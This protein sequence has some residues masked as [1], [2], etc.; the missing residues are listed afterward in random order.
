VAA[1]ESEIGGSNKRRVQVR[2][3][4]G[5]KKAK[6]RRNGFTRERKND[7]LAHF[8]ATCNAKASARA[9]GV[10][11]ATVYQ[12]RKSDP[13]FR[14]SWEEALDHGYARLEAE[15]VRRAAL[16]PGFDADEEAAKECETIDPKLA[17]A[18]LESYRRNRGAKPGDILPRT[19]DA[20]QVRARLEKKMR[21]LRIVDQDGRLIAPAEPEAG[22]GE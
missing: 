2:A 22:E 9:A 18:I 6:P 4:R 11:H 8:A 5:S 3:P 15:L 12:H 20:E 16:L 21:A 7:F 14:A 1:D 17:L 10:A 13:A 19:S